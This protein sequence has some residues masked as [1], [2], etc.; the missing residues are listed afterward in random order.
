MTYLYIDQACKSSEAAGGCGVWGP[1]GTE[2]RRSSRD[3][4]FDALKLLNS[5]VCKGEEQKLRQQINKI[6]YKTVHKNIHIKISVC[7]K[8][9]KTVLNNCEKKRFI[10]SKHNKNLHTNFHTLQISWVIPHKPKKMTN[11]IRGEKVDR[12]LKNTLKHFVITVVGVLHTNCSLDLE[13]VLPTVIHVLCCDSYMIITTLVAGTSSWW[14]RVS[15]APIKSLHY[16]F[17]R[18][19]SCCWAQ[20]LS[21]FKL[22]LS[23]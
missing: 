13:A 8:N 4:F 12:L 10:L 19:K 23:F 5:I 15:V 1:W 18:H 16:F 7:N 9:N 21:F 20:V 6:F 22:T 14:R 11:P 17:W 3:I 2:Y